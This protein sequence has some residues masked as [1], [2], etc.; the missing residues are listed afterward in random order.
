MKDSTMESTIS[1]IQLYVENQIPQ[2]ASEKSLLAGSIGESPSKYSRSPG[3]W[4][5]VF[6]KLDF[7]AA[8]V[9]FDV[10]P[11]NLSNFVNALKNYPGFMG[12]NV[13]VPY[14]LDIMNLLDSIDITASQIGAVNT[15]A[16]NI[17]QTLTGFNTDADGLISSMLQRLPGESE[18]F[19]STLKGKTVL[20]LGAGGAGR[21]AAFAIASQIEEGTL[22]MTNRSQKRVED[23][24][25]EV[26]ATV[27]DSTKILAIPAET[28][29]L[30]MPELDVIVNASTVGQ[31]GIRAL[32]NKSLTS[33][34]PFSS[35]SPANPPEIN[36]QNDALLFWQKWFVLS[37]PEITLNNQ[38]SM[39]AITSAKSSAVFVDAVYSPNETVLLRHARLSG[40]KTLNGRGMLIMQAAS[41]F[42]NR[43]TRRHLEN[44]GYDPDSLY[45]FVVE[46][47]SE[48][49]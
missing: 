33:L 37:Y 30:Y 4:N 47:M 18:S 27:S 39:Q 15:F 19:I 45:D 11:E 23:L 12:A 44:A 1:D 14:K 10:R 3:M 9:P 5:A 6:K 42:V 35:L 34:E 20:L 41:S 21:A 8:Y 38:A 7:D 29:N 17:D 48:A 22:Y 32:T 2:I 43:M 49:F 36:D 28:V 24:A 40:R 25:Y 13:T 26:Q 16:L 31:S 46:T